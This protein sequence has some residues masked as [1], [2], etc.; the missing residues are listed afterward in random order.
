[1]NTPSIIKFPFWRRVF[2]NPEATYTRVA[3][4]AAAP[5]EIT[6]RS[7]AIRGDIAEALASARE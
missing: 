3:L 7:L 6:D 1:M 2:D 4:D 5:A